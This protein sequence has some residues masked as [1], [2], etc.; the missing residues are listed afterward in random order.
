MTVNKF[1]TISLDVSL[2]IGG[3]VLQGLQAKP[4]RQNTADL[5]KTKQIL[6]LLSAILR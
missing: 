6:W 4:A 2:V 1:L 5:L 3:L